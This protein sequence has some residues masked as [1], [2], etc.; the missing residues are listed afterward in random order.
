MS[1][2]VLFSRP[3]APL[4]RAAT[5]LLLAA[6]SLLP[7]APAAGALQ[8]TTH[9]RAAAAAR[10][11]THGAQKHAATHAAGAKH[12]KITGKSSGRGTRPQRNAR[13]Q[14]THGRVHR[15]VVK[16][17][18]RHRALSARETAKTQQ[19]QHAFVASTQLRPMAQQLGN[20]RSAAAYSGVEA[21]AHAHTGAAAAAA[22]LALGHA[23]LLDHRY[24][25]SLAALTSANAAGNSLDDYADYFSAQAYL[26]SNQSAQADALLS[27]FPTKYPD[28]I[29]TPQ[30]PILEANLLL[31]QSQAPRAL[32][33]LRAHSGDALAS[34]PDYQ[35]ALAKAEYQNGQSA[36]ALALYKRLLSEHPLSP[37]A[38]A[39]QQQLQSSGQWLTLS[40]NERRQ[41]ADALLSG[42]K[43]NEAS[44]EFRT[45]AAD[46]TLNQSERNG[47]LLSAATCDFKLKRLSAGSLSGIPDSDDDNGAHRLYLLMEVARSAQDTGTQQDL[48][49]QLRTRF[50]TSSWLAEAL[51]SSGNLYMLKRDY[52]SAIPYYTELARRFP[53]S[54]NADNAHWRAAWLNYRL[55]NFPEAGRLMDEQ[56]TTFR[57]GKNVPA[58]LYWRGRLFLD[59]Q[60]D[61][62]TAA[63]YFA[64]VTR[65]FQHFYYAAI[66]Q[67]RLDQIG[68]SVT[69]AQIAS[70][71]ALQPEQIPTLT[72]DVPESDPHL[73]KAALL[74]NAGLN[75]YLAQ[76]IHA[77]EGSDEWGSLAEARLYASYG[78]SYRAMRSLKKAIPF[79]TSAPIDELPL[80][81]WRILFPQ[82]YWATIKQEAAANHLD[83]Y[84]VA[85]LIRQESEF[86]PRVVSYANAWGLMQLLPSTGRQMAQRTG[87]STHLDSAALLDPQINIK[88]G[89]AYLRQTLD[90]Y[91]NQQEYAF[92]S[93]NAG[94]ARVDDW[95]AT[96]DYTGID[97]WV[98][99]IPF[100]ET[101]DYVQAIMRN[102]EIY[103][104]LDKAATTRA[105]INAAASTGDATVQ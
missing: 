48:V 30:M 28:S 14:R 49:N 22:Y 73:A 8:H 47:L 35:L 25:E 105:T 94:E 36:D 99:S 23:Y 39:A 20:Y 46:T 76:E 41:H 72:E 26:Q 69:P 71:D 83:P 64:T 66:A 59:Q 10:A 18:A 13:G 60:H 82:D 34:K 17:H 3:A 97:E 54:K 65:V 100:T 1:R 21:F 104:E 74:A 84:M 37:E 56:L 29:F 31:A 98:E 67:Q 85:S 101:R 6:A 58:A 63:A 38:M 93:Y 50:Q 7:F 2:I 33:V 88:L 75:D 86:N 96:T 103:R 11:K 4:C 92:A 40:V 9:A 61:P 89:C 102:E 43:Y 52:P 24:T 51:F 42:G 68:A 27:T 70:L 19:L 80:D 55:R 44:S 5:A 87:F 91:N 90:R 15:V 32:T 78:E 12:G 16:R 62:A 81:Y 79:Y 45:L 57:D 53:Q 77:A 95:K